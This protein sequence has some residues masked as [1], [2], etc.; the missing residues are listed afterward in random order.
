MIGDDPTS[1][2]VEAR[3]AARDMSFTLG[4]GVCEKCRHVGLLVKTR[5]YGNLCADQCLETNGTG[6]PPRGS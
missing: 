3:L 6:D 5:R 1:D 4:Y 2:L